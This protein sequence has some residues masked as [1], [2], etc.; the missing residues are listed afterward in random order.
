MTDRAGSEGGTDVKKGSVLRPPESDFAAGCGRC[1]ATVMGWSAATV[2]L[3]TSTPNDA[4][5]LAS[6]ILM[7]AQ[8]CAE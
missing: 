3:A 1:A 2:A 7:R 6:K 8:M 5:R 4:Q